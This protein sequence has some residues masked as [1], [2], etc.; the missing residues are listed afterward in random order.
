MENSEL[1]V[2]FYA[3]NGVT[4]WSQYPVPN[5][6]NTAIAVVEPTSD[7][8]NED[9]LSDWQIG[10]VLGGEYLYPDGSSD[11]IKIVSFKNN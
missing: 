11:R 8:P 3:R 6:L 1:I 9:S 7:W 2:Y 5:G 10:D 4:F